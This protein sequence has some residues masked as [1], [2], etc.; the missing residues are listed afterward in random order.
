MYIQ[1]D[2]EEI[3]PLW[4]E[5][6]LPEDEDGEKKSLYYNELTAQLSLAKPLM[7]NRCKGG[8]LADEMGLGKTVMMASLIASGIEK[9]IKKNEA[10]NLVVVP[11]T[12]LSQW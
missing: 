1:P 9:N 12:L 3:H 6:A 10:Q 8:I 5:Y 4:T 2:A 11:L 7:K